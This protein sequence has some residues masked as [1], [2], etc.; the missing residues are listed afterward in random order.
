M[1]KNLRWACDRDTADRICNFNRHY[2][3][4]SGYFE[5]TNFIDDAKVT[6]GEINFYDSNTGKLLFTAPKGRT[7]E[8][9]LLE[10]RR[11]GAYS[12]CANCCWSSFTMVGKESLMHKVTLY[13]PQAGPGKR[14]PINSLVSG[15]STSHSMVP[16][17]VLLMRFLPLSTNSFRDEEV[18]WENVRILP[19]GEAVSVFGTRK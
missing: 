14:S 7:M 16:N 11:H 3:E 12:V 10:S 2:A 5:K 4:H 1:Q 8:Q 19:D 18:N 6:K 15:M 13:C 9:F 17:T